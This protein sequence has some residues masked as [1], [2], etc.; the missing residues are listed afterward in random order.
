MQFLKKYKKQIFSIFLLILSIIAAFL[1]LQVQ[2]LQREERY[3]DRQVRKLKSI[4][5]SMTKDINKVSAYIENLKKFENLINSNRDLFVDYNY[6]LNI[7]NQIMALFTNNKDKVI[8]SSPKVNNYEFSFFI[9]FKDP[10]TF[11]EF[12]KN[13]LLSKKK[14][15]ASLVGYKENKNIFYIKLK[16]YFL[17]Q[18]TK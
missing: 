18:E 1:H 3:Y 5:T 9:E 8:L 17:L 7:Y 4:L 6:A 11:N 10:N 16:I 2:N 14:I 12:L 13:F 15:Y